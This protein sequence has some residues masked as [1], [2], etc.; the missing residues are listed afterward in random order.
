MTVSYTNAAAATTTFT[1]LAPRK[2]VTAS[3]KCLKPRRG[4][5]GKRCTRYVS[6]GSFTHKDVAGFNTFV[7]TG[8][9]RHHKL[10]RGSY[11]LQGV[12]SANGRKSKAVA[13]RFRIVR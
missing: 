11:K 13:L 8:R 4:R 6:L 1:V 10:R 3:A 9:V 2:G 7:F 5:H 12:S